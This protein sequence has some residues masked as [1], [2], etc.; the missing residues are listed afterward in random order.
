MVCPEPHFSAGGILRRDECPV[1]TRSGDT[2]PGLT[3]TGGSDCALGT[4]VPFAVQPE[5]SICSTCL[6]S[7]LPVLSGM[8]PRSLLHISVDSPSVF[9]LGRILGPPGVEWDLRVG[10]RGAAGVDQLVY[11]AVAR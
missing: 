6:A 1:L 10:P 2:G 3:A 5:R 7:T 8:P 4:D 11:L 9:G